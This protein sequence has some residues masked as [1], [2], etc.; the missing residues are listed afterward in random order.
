MNIRFKGSVTVVQM[1]VSQ[2]AENLV[3][4]YPPFPDGVDITSGFEVLTN[5]VGEKVYGNY[6]AYTTI[7]RILDDGCV[8]LSNNGKVWE[9]PV[10]NVSF[11]GA[12]CSISGNSNQKVRNYGDIIIPNVIPDENYK[13]LGWIPEVPT[14]GNIEKDITFSAHMGYMPTLNELKA[15]KK[16]EISEACERIIINGINV[17]M[18]GGTVEHFSLTEHDQINL[19]GKQSQLASGADRL[20][21]HED[22]HLCR[23]YTA[24]EMLLII[25]VAMQHVS[26]HTTYCNSLNMWISGVEK[27]EEL[28]CIFYG[29][30]IPQEYQSEV[31]KDYLAKIMEESE[32]A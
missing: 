2:I 11:D 26:Y 1:D 5:S 13:F 16:E 22:G 28:D 8:I 10:Y 12:N 30:D 31:L 29:V 18:P 7:Y 14:T 3:M 6:L 23:Y 19:F 21:Y 4:L 24:E 17:K 27:K 15:A 25:T 20:E 32:V 9:D